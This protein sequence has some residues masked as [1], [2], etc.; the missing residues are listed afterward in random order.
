MATSSFYTPFIIDKK[1]AKILIKG[2]EG[3]KPPRPVD[4]GE[5]ERGSEA[6]KRYALRLEKREA[7]LKKTRSPKQ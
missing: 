7:A 2:L 6:L 4:N 5:F 3:P 1:A